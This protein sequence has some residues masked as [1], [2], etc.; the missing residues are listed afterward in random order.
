MQTD[1]CSL[2][3]LHDIIQIAM[4]WQDEHMFAFVI[5]GKQYG[6]L[7]RGATLNTIPVPFVSAILPSRGTPDF[8]TIMILGMGGNT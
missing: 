7:E 1:D 6:D 8:N 4:G 2:D 3:E 5:D